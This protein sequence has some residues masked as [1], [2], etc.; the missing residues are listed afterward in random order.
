MAAADD[1]ILVWSAERDLAAGEQVTSDDLSARAVRFVEGPGLAEYLL[2]ET[3]VPEGTRV[4]RSVGAGELLPRSAL[5]PATDTGVIEVP[6]AVDAGQLPPSVGA[7]SIVSVW[8]AGEVA[9]TDTQTPRATLVLADVVVIEAPRVTDAFGA[10]AE[11]QLV[12][13]VPVD[14]A[15]DLA[16]AVGAAA[17]GRVVITRQG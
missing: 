14:Q 6:V 12:L 2:A 17:S 4:G 3:G 15:G 1:T 10:G 5:A 16:A 13:G 9:P 11:R 8:V 7:G